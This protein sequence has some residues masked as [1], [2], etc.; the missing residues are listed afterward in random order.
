VCH[1]GAD[2]VILERGGWLLWWLE[3]IGVPPDDI[4]GPAPDHVQDYLAT[5]QAELRRIQAEQPTMQRST[6]CKGRTV[7]YLVSASSVVSI[8]KEEM[9]ATELDIAIVYS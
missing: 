6:T 8:V 7:G 2:E 3:E 4:S 5:G 9:F 1:A